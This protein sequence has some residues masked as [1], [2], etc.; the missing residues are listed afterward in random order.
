MTTNVKP[1]KPQLPTK[2][3]TFEHEVL[4]QNFEKALNCLREIL[5]Q[6]E[7]GKEGMGGQLTICN[8]ASEQEA[9]A[10][11]ASYTSMLCN[12]KFV[13]TRN[14]L[15]M[16]SHFKRALS[17]VFEVSGYRG[18]GHFIRLFGRKSDNGDVTLKGRDIPK[19]FCG[20]SLN[21]MTEPLL[22][23]F[24]RQPPDMTWPILNGFLSEQLLYSPLAETIRGKLLA[25]SDHW[26]NVTPIDGVVRNL[27]PAYMGCSYADAAHKHD[28]KHAMNSVARRWMA[29]NDVTGL[30]FEGE[31][32]G[33]KRKPTLI[34]MA[35]LYNSTHA[36]HR[37]YGP[38]IRALKDRF[39]L[40]YMSLE[41]KCDPEIE[42]MFD[43]IDN[44]KFD[45]KDPKPFFDKAKSYR[46]DVVYYPSVGMRLMSILGSNLRLAPI[47]VMT[48]GHPATTNSDCMDYAVIVDGQLGDEGT[49]AEKIL[50][51]PSTPRWQKR[52][53]AARIEPKFSADPDVVRIAVPA[54]SRKVTPR[55]LST[56]QTIQ[57]RASRKVEFVFF[58][59]GVGALFQSF[60]RRVEG[61]MN[62]TVLPRADY[63]TYIGNL[64]KCD[65]FLSTFPFGATNGII[66]AALQG[67]PVVN[68]HGGEVHAANDAD[69]VAKFKQPDWLTTHSV[70]EYTE[71]VLR[72]VENGEE[73]VAI[74]KSIAEFDHDNGL[75]IAPED[76][77][78][79]FGVAVEAAY[80]HHETLQ[81]ADE[82]AFSY[83]YLRTLL[84]QGNK[85]A[86]KI[87]IGA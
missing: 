28:I 31:H 18:T 49:I 9:T 79:E 16:L 27:G 51:R 40:V 69:I 11:A 42:F 87:K 75:L 3:E 54:W 67:I 82:T 64:N 71:A 17:Q 56:C 14:S 5:V 81:S 13:L 10:L 36:M 63:N 76:Y 30:S 48:Y 74:S 21:A 29:D 70:E 61:M 12:P 78:E 46:P 85:V 66:D 84:E 73:R 6:I 47:Q 53:D 8:T 22:E 44:T 60:K 33:V 68:L 50:Y 20:L 1:A 2:I 83:D 80:R 62:A 58:P 32:R 24:M 37:C 43:K 38:A 57:K 41:G 34:V 4:A 7:G 26:I 52:L 77:C 72:L 55:F 39:K 35:E 25:S 86:S 59:N 65:I 15:M 45:N 23:L 19:L